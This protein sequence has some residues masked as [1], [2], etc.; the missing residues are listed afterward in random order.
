MMNMTIR[1][2]TS[3]QYKGVAFHKRR[4]RW[5]ADIKFDRKNLYLGHFD[6]E[7]DAARAYNTKAIELFGELAHLN[8]VDY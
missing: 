8:P 6:T 4:S 1:T 5:C 7:E 3:S 2:G